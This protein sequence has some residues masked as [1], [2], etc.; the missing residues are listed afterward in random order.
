[1]IPSME[2]KTGTTAQGECH[3]SLMMGMGTQPVRLA[4]GRISY[5][6]SS[7]VNSEAWGGQILRHF[8]FKQACEKRKKK[9]QKGFFFSTAARNWCVLSF[10]TLQFC[11]PFSENPQTTVNVPT[12][13]RFWSECMY[14][15]NE[16]WLLAVT[17][18]TSCC[19]GSLVFLFILGP[20]QNLFS[21]TRENPREFVKMYIMLT[22]VSF[23]WGL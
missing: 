5:G 8:I 1:M 22:W 7:Q 3:S 2:R 12:D 18:I 14:L 4:S 20:Q 10:V 23:W 15:Q 6:H 16:Y 21:F 17:T 11:F 9:K 13:Y 19:Y